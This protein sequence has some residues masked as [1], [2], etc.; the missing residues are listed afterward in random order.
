MIPCQ[1]WDVTNCSGL[2]H[3]WSRRSFFGRNSATP[4]FRWSAASQNFPGVQWRYRARHP[5]KNRFGPIFS[6][7]IVM[8]CWYCNTLW[9]M[10]AFRAMKLQ[11]R[12]ASAWVPAT[13]ESWWNIEKDTSHKT[14]WF[15]GGLAN[16]KTSGAFLGQEKLSFQHP[17]QTSDP[18]AGHCGLV[19]KWS[20]IDL[21]FQEHC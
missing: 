19:T 15:R 20:T 11:L 1:L 7:G 2:T 21:N 12:F 9:R 3:P 8:V 13:S 17:K 5:K 18:R 6:H 10:L 4:M 14:K 16:S